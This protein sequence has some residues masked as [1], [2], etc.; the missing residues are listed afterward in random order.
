VQPLDG[1]ILHDQNINATNAII[2]IYSDDAIHFSSQKITIQVCNAKIAHNV[3]LSFYGMQTNLYGF[4]DWQWLLESFKCRD[5]FCLHNDVSQLYNIVVPDHGFDLLLE[6]AEMFDICCDTKLMLTIRNNIPLDYDLEKFSIE[7]VERLSAI[8]NYHIVSINSLGV[9]R[10][11]NPQTYQIDGT[12]NNNDSYR[13]HCMVI[14]PDNSKIAFNN[15]SRIII[16]DITNGN[17]L[18]ILCGHTDIVN[19]MNFSI[20]GRRIL[21]SSR[22]RIIKLWDVETGRLLC[23]SETDSTFRSLA[24]SPCGLKFASCGYL[25]A[26]ITLWNLATLT[27]LRSF[28]TNHSNI[29]N[30]ILFLDKDKLVSASYDSNIKIWDIVTDKL[31]TT[32]VDQKNPSGTSCMA[33]SHDKLKI[34]SSHDNVKIW[35]LITGQLLMTLPIN[36]A[37]YHSVMVTPDNLYIISCSYSI[38]IWELATG[39]LLAELDGNGYN[40]IEIACRV[41]KNEIDDKLSEFMRQSL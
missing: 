2:T 21:S 19:I 14:S 11:Y 39:K 20:G 22:D 38:K 37:Y 3:I 28:E 16:Q 1:V 29:I 34:I 23:T 8:K 41:I 35:D 32:L 6:V 40:I 33:V 26:S 30:R 24:V 9:I 15:Y 5:Y 13:S 4:P 12:H 17:I 10:M 18:S 36:N 31:L 25:G 27:V 7:F